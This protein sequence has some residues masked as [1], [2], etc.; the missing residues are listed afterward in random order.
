MFRRSWDHIPN[1]GSRK[2]GGSATAKTHGGLRLVLGSLDY[3][4]TAVSLTDLIK[5]FQKA[6]RKGL[7]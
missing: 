3:R 4:L 5:V 2:A 1:P 7:T 6:S